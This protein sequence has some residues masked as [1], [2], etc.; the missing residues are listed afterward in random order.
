MVWCYE[1]DDDLDSMLYEDDD[2]SEDI[3]EEVKNEVNH[4]K[5][6]SDDNNLSP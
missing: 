4:K 6:D 3:K 5:K 1:C 2:E